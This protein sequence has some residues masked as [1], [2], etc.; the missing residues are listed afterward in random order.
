M[1]L[2]HVVTSKAFIDRTQVE[3]PGT[4]FVLPRRR[5]GDGSASSNCCA[6]CWRCGSSAA[7]VRRGPREAEPGRPAPAGGGAVHQRPREG[8]EGGAA[9]ARQHH[10]RPARP[11][12]AGLR[13]STA[14]TRVLGFLPMFHSFGLTVTGPVPAARR[15]PGRP[16]P[17]PDRRR[18]PGPQARRVQADDPRRHADVRGLHPRPGQAGRPRLARGSWSSG[19]RSARTRCS[20]R[21]E[22]ARPARACCRGLRHHRV[23][24]GGV[25]ATR[26]DAVRPGTVGKPLPGVEVCVTDLETGEVL[27]P[28]EMGMLLRHR[29]DGVPRLPRRRRPVAVP[30]RSTASGGTSP[31]TWRRSTPTATFASTAG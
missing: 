31:A 17:G 29:A 10:H 28:G 13:S 21:L 3:V 12:V 20:R 8:P 7:R 14:P 16:P 25:G 5:A 30:R 24:A 18:R 11:R 1:G 22:G 19:R 15:R 6:G 2:T 4:E 9:D 23:L 26:P 27:P